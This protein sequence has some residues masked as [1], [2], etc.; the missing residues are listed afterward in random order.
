MVGVVVGDEQA[1]DVPR[2][3][4]LGHDVGDDLLAAVEAG[5]DHPQALARV[6]D[7][8]VRVQPAGEV[9]AVIPATDEVEMVV[10]LHSASSSFGME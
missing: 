6:D 3:E 8:A 9:E 2:F 4:A 7:V 5:V 1:G 10:D